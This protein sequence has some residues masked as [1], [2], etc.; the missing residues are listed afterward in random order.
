[1]PLLNSVGEHIWETS[2][3]L[4]L[5]GLR[6]DHRMVVAQLRSGKL[7]IHSPVTWSENLDNELKAIGPIDRFV[8]PNR[9]HDLYW[10]EW[11]RQYP[12]ATFYCA[13]GMEKDHPDLGFHHILSHIQGEEWEDE[14]KKLH[15]RGVPKINE[16]VFLHHRSRSLIVSDLVMQFDRRQNLL[17]KLFLQWDGIYDRLNISRLYRF[18]IRDNDA[19]QD[20]IKEMLSW[21]FEQIIVGHGPI[22]Q[23]DARQVL[24]STLS[25]FIE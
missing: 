17:G 7:W 6:C 13:P 1:M 11:F 4:K 10:P 25:S 20:S 18:C 15:I 2:C 21:E 19:F 3:P 16:F 23:G 14:L 24:E 22:V 5:P 9:F 12:D 8:A